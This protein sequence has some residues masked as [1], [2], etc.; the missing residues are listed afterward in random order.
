MISIY[1]LASLLES[2]KKFEEA[3]ELFREELVASDFPSMLTMSFS[4]RP[5]CD[6]G[7][8]SPPCYFLDLPRHSILWRSRRDHRF[9][10]EFCEISQGPRRLLPH[11]ATVLDEILDGWKSMT[12]SV[13]RNPTSA[14]ARKP[15]R[16]PGT[17]AFGRPNC[18]GK[19]VHHKS[20]SF[21][22]FILRLIVPSPKHLCITMQKK[23]YMIKEK[24]P[25]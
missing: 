20:C 14:G 5:C 25:Q 2:M 10:E 6:S 23:N 1:N 3:E 7:N 4:L 17:S 11:T 19:V 24:R 13:S 8:G 15:R 12:V 18:P 22:R 16:G 9:Q 21:L